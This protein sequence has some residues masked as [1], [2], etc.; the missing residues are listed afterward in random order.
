[1]KNTNEA[2]HMDFQ[3]PGHPLVVAFGGINAGL[4]IPPFEFFNLL[5]GVQLNK[6]F[7]RDYEQTWYQLGVNEDFRTPNDL[8]AHIR[9]LADGSP[10]ITLGNSMGGYAAILFGVLVQARQVIAFSP[11][12]F[13]DKWNRLVFFDRRWPRQISRTQ[14]EV[15]RNGNPKHYLDLRSFLALHDY[16]TEIEVHYSSNHR[17]DRI[18]SERLRKSKHVSLSP[19]RT[20]T[21]LLTRELRD[22]QELQQIL[23]NHFRAANL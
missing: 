18:H 3:S 9:E 11:Q 13:L 15:E 7:I 12:T 17:L 5:N 10:I 23:T 8:A 21:H 19:H 2:I 20:N 16:P 14:N 4:G 1:M 22:S 6:L